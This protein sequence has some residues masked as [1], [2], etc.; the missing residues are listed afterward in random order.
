MLSTPLPLDTRAV[1]AFALRDGAG[2]L[3]LPRA[4][5]V[6]TGKAGQGHMASVSRPVWGTNTTSVTRLKNLGK[7][8]TRRSSCLNRVNSSAKVEEVTGGLLLKPFTARPRQIGGGL[9]GPVIS[10]RPLAHPTPRSRTSRRRPSNGSAKA[11]CTRAHR[12]ARL[13]D[14]FDAWLGPRTTSPLRPGVSIPLKM[15][16]GGSLK[17]IH[18]P[19][20]SGNGPRSLSAH[21][22]TFKLSTAHPPLLYWHIRPFER[23]KYGIRPPNPY[24][25][26]SYSR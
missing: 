21:G 24:I 20:G 3:Q 4:P 2:R 1:S 16:Q 23:E 26:G 6:H 9:N 12:P 13:Q 25:P 15:G 11:N 18:R 5:P 14:D 19:K 17:V 8:F 10:S 7:G 22:G